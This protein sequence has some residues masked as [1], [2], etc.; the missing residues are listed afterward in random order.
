MK[1]VLSRFLPVILWMVVIFGFSAR[2]DP[3][4][5]LPTAWDEPQVS[6][7]PV[8]AGTPARTLPS[9]DEIIGRFLHVGEYLLL[10]FLVIRA[11]SWN[12]AIRAGNALLSVGLSILYALSDEFHQIYVPGRAF[13]VADLLLDLTGILIGVGIY[14]FINKS[15][16]EKHRI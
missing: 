3:Y 1:T 4:A 14:F 10:G 11:V 15:Q 2:S 7:T 8:P 9:T 5:Y 12:R 16:N 13:Q 6:S